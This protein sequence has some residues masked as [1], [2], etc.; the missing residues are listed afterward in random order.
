MGKRRTEEFPRSAHI[1]NRK[2]DHDGH[3]PD[4]SETEDNTVDQVH[5]CV[6]MVNRLDS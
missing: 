4:V 5:I 3:D 1:D 6:N 2:S